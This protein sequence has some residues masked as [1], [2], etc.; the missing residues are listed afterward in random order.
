[1][2][3]RDRAEIEPSLQPIFNNDYSAIRLVV[4][5]SNLT[6]EEI[7]SFAGR[8]DAWAT[9]N[10]SDE[11]KIT[12]GDNTILRARISSVLTT[13]LMQGFAMSFVLITLT[14]MIGLRSIRYGLLSIMPNVYPATIVFGFWGLLVGELSP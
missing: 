8:I 6:N 12:R 1:M 2:C 3:I 14:M 10:V 13:E 4:G 7:L 11:F 5:T 9:D